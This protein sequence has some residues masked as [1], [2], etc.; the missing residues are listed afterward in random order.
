MVDRKKVKK[1]FEGKSQLWPTI[2]I[3][4]GL[5]TLAI[6]IGIF[7]LIVG[8]IWFLYNKFSVDLSG[9]SEVDKAKQYEIDLA[10]D[11][12]KAKMNLID[13]QI[14][15]VEPVVI[16]G[17]GT[18]PAYVEGI[19][20]SAN[21]I[22]NLIKRLFKTESKKIK[23]AK[24]DDYAD[25][26]QMARIG[27]DGVYR[28][29]LMSTSVFMFGEKQLYIYFSEVDLSTGVVYSEGMFEVFY[30]D[31]NALSFVQ[32]KEKV[33]NFKKKRYEG[34]LFESV[35]LF[36]SGCNYTASVFTDLDKSLVEKEFA[37]M[38]SLIRDRK[39]A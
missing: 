24:K 21:G 34:I 1:Y 30:S 9:E 29:S 17:R 12:A 13:E 7:L 20:K 37:G 19:L 5:F 18:Q 23:K 22:L 32:D 11:R 33:Y 10:R 31:I 2:L 6:V 14:Q 8:I 4:V 27:S 16:S 35:K 26:I 28:C 25:P 15:N 36:A 39:E 38:R 3:I